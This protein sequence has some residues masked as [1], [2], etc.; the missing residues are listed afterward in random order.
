MLDRGQTEDWFGS[1]F[2][3]VSATVC[4]LAFLFMIPWELRHENPVVDL[5]MVASRQF[6]SCF[7][8]M[9][10]TGAILI[11]TTQFVPELLQSFYGYTATWAGMALSP[12]G[13][14]TMTMMFVVG[15]VTA[16]VQP[17]YLIALGA[18]I[19][20]AAMWDLTRLSPDANFGY[21]VWSRIFVGLGLPLIF[22]P[23]TTASYDGIPKNKTDQASALINVAR[24]VGGSIGVSIAQNTLAFREQFHQSRLVEHITPSSPA[25]HQT[26]EATVA[27][28]R[29][30]GLSAPDA[31]QGAIAL[32]GQTLQQQVGYLAYIDVFHVLM[33]I[34]LCAVPLAL[35]LRNVKPGGGARPAPTDRW[36]ERASGRRL[37]LDRQVAQERVDLVAAE[38]R[39]VE[40]A[41]CAHSLEAVRIPVRR[42]D[43]AHRPVRE[44]A[45]GDRIEGEKRDVA[46]PFVL[47]DPLEGGLDGGERAFE[48]L[49]EAAGVEEERAGDPVAGVVRPAPDEDVV[50]M[51]RERRGVAG[52]VVAAVVDEAVQA[53]GHRAC[54]SRSLIC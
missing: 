45:R 9:M 8:V 34:S 50:D 22:I 47:L 20:A 43:E 27:M 11:A 31:E 42:A 37:L 30:R 7:L 6:G 14:V 52:N 54:P 44:A 25:Y 33:L 23:I 46:V 53:G 35:I 21:F 18:A 12:G 17:K 29:A 5:R 28:L 3:I 38:A 24:N 2:I 10:A 4:V 32:I 41:R 40:A 16:I 39:R 1:N 15:R 48:D 51:G 49:R 13:I 36:P 19:V 26:M